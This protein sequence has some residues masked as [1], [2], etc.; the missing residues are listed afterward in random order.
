MKELPFTKR[1][2]ARREFV[3]DREPELHRSIRQTWLHLW[4][5]GLLFAAAASTVTNELLGG[6]TSK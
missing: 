4:L 6:L 5:W 3:R 2:R 1:R